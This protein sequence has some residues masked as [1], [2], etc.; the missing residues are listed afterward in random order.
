MFVSSGAIESARLLLLSSSPLE[1]HGLG[2]HS[3]HL[4]RHVQGHYYSIA[5]GLLPPDVEPSLLGPG[6][7]VATTQFNHGN[8][9]IIGGAILANDFVKLPLIFWRQSLPP[10]TPR[11]GLANK[12]AMRD[13]FRRGIDVRGLVQEIPSPDSRVTLD[14]AVHDPF[15]LPVARLSGTT[16]PETV[17]TAEFMRAR[18][19]EW[20][21]ASGA[22]RVWSWPAEKKFSAG[23]HQA[24]TCRMSANP[25]NRVTD[26]FG[27]V[28]GHDHLLVCDGSLH[29]INGGF[30]PALTIMALAFRTAEHILTSPKTSAPRNTT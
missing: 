2:N 26:P 7:S 10:D 28:H 15:G 12:R 20:L 17:R 1:F 30:N 11:W 18:A 13:L 6:V 25:R 24:G 21:R 23:Q 5:D 14:P 22:E 19:E 29:V 9:G 16:P 27:R 4:G 8:P 3:D